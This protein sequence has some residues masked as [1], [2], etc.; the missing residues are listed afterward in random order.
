M[1]LN[2]MV[3]SPEDFQKWVA[4]QKA[5]ALA[6]E[7]VAAG[8][9]VYENNACVNCHTIAGTDSKG[10]FGP[11]LTHLMS[12]TTI[13]SGAAPNDE[14]DLRQWIEDP[15]VIKPG[16]LM[17]AMQ[18]NQQDISSLVAYLMTLR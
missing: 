16:C 4:Q 7:Q 14:K 3:D 12:R 6:S 13:A 9:R 11:D 1:L 8:R 5:P 2:V 15:D 10:T 18:L 17:P